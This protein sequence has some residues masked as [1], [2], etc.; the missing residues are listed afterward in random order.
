MYHVSHIQLL[1]QTERKILL[2]PFL[3]QKCI[4]IRK[5]KPELLQ[6]WLKIK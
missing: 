3:Q 4:K 2:K 1:L 5:I 6:E